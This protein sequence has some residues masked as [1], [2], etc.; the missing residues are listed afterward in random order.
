MTELAPELNRIRTHLDEVGQGHLLTFADSLDPGS[1][2]SLLAQIDAIDLKTVPGL[3]DRYVRSAE[4]FEV[5]GDLEP[6]PYYPRE[7]GTG[8]D[9]KQWDPGA[10]RAAGEALISDGKIACFTVAGGQG[11]R[12]GYDG[13]KGCYPTSCVTGKPLFEMF[14]EQILASAR[15]YGAIIPW[16]IM[17]SPLNHDAT[18]AFFDEHDQFGMDRENVAFFQQGVMPSFDLE[19]GKILLAER[20]KVATN[21]DGHGGALLALVKS[22]AIDDMRARG[23]EH[24]SYIQVDNPLAKCVDPVFLG[25]HASADDS[26]GEMSS[27]MLAKV[28]AREKVGVFCRTGGKT[29]VIEYSDMPDAL[30]EAT[31]AAGQL[32]F[33]AG[34]IAIH[35]IGVDFVTR[36]VSDPAL[37][38]PYHRAVKKV[39]HV[40]LATGERVEPDEPNGVKL[41][42]FVF[43]AIPLAGSSIVYETDRVEEFAPVKNAEGT[44]SIVTSRALQSERAARML[45]AAGVTVP[46]GAGGELNCVIELSPFTGLDADELRTRRGTLPDSIDPGAKVSL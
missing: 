13:P 41:E 22:G 37:Q 9:S 45:E 34:S 17:T 43:D 24:I 21:P 36:V 46:R 42:R 1:L 33:L 6:A 3:V 11:T 16:Y 38:L 35:A 8:A 44:D 31:D 12:L 27:K 25:L 18:I 29:A 19:T 26:S 14:A 32:R 15:R 39:P 28:D 4:A 20:G 23:I 10:A 7:P 5:P 2:E 40:D 30:A